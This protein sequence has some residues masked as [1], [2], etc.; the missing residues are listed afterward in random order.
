MLCHVLTTGSMTA[1]ARYFPISNMQKDSDGYR[2]S[3]KSVYSM[4]VSNTT[5]LLNASSG[6]K[7]YSN[8]PPDKTTR[9]ET[10]WFLGPS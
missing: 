3:F 5:V 1:E 9:S 7:P 10:Y 4:L 6:L 2:V 8:S